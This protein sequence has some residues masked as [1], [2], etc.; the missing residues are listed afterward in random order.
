MPKGIT[1]AVGK[2]LNRVSTVLKF[3]HEATYLLYIVLT[4]IDLLM[5]HIADPQAFQS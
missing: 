1:T 3:I 2:P 4:L 5:P